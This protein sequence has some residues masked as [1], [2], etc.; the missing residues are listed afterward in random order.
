MSQAEIGVIGGSGLYAM[1]SLEDVEEV[2]LETPFGRPSAPYVIGTLSGKRVAF[3]PRHGRGHVFLPGDIPFRANIH[4]FKQLGCE[5]IISVS[6]VGS[7]REEIVPGHLVIP[8][9]FIDLTKTRASTFF[10]DG[11]VAHVSMADPVCARLS[12]ILFEAA[13]E[14]GATVHAG[15]TYVCMEGPQFSTRAESFR[16]RDWKASVIGMTNMPEA[17]LAREAEF[18]YATL[19]LATDYDCWH[20]EEEA[21]NVEAII[22]LL[23]RN[24]EL[25][26]RVITGAVSRIEGK[27]PF[28]G[29]LAG[30]I[31][32]DP[33]AIPKETRE[34]LKLLTG[35][36]L[37]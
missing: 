9:Q 2:A 26:Q 12:G 35:R 15:G 32:T 16:Y 13:R 22:A 31:I 20:E 8:D 1:K 18:S 30:A 19:A 29:S 7:L 27:S 34:R 24:V 36:Y 14:A 37:S 21:A 4:G 25:A 5:W 10:G 17:K 3:L 28:A 11:L 33:K 23:H 6:A